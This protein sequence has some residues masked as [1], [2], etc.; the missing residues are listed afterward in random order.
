MSTNCQL[1]SINSNPGNIALA[2]KCIF[3]FAFNRLINCIAFALSRQ[4]DPHNPTNPKDLETQSRG[5]KVTNTFPLQHFFLAVDEHPLQFI[6]VLLR[7]VF[8]L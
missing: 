5:E 4:S 3:I 2:K 8:G 7:V 1:I 6:D